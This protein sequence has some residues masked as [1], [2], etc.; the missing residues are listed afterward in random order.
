[1]RAMEGKLLG[2]PLRAPITSSDFL[3]ELASKFVSRLC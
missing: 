3:L 2:I 1:M